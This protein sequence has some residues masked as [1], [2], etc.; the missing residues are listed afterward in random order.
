MLMEFVGARKEEGGES[1]A[2]NTRVGV[3]SRCDTIQV[4]EDRQNGI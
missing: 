2:E 4:P 3:R 1:S